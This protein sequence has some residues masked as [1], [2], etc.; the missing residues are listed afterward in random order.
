MPTSISKWENIFGSNPWVEHEFVTLSRAY[1]KPL[2]CAD[3]F[4][5]GEDLDPF[6]KNELGAVDIPFLRPPNVSLHGF[7]SSLDKEKVILLLEW[8]E[9]LIINYIETFPEV[10]KRSIVEGKWL[11]THR[12]YQ[13]PRMSFL[14]ILI[15]N[16]VV[17]S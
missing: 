12:G 4:E 5:G 6:I 13:S 15:G 14:S 7:S 9:Y 1:L 10:F 8:I 16:L 3:G 2:T 17:F 11:K